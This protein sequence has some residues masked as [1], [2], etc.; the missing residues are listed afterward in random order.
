MR[1]MGR[2]VGIRLAEMHSAFDCPRFK[3]DMDIVKFTCKELWNILFNKFADKLQT[4]HQGLFVVYDNDFKLFKNVSWNMLD[5]QHH[6]NDRFLRT[7]TLIS[8]FPAGIIEGAL[9][10]LDFKAS[11]TAEIE[12]P[13]CMTFLT[14]LFN[15]QLQNPKIGI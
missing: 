7:C 12:Y 6:L 10:N 11:V 3:K 9:E 1:E 15:R 4:N 5:D 2:A 13:K 8:D 14:F